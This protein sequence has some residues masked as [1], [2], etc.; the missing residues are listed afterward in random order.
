[1]KIPHQRRQQIPH[2]GLVALFLFYSVLR[3]QTCLKTGKRM[4]KRNLGHPSYL[5]VSCTGYRILADAW[6][7]TKHN[8]RLLPPT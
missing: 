8:K 2:Q 7:Q 3:L 6:Y 5:N 1:M 4:K